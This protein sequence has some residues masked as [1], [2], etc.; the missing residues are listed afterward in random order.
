MKR[1]EFILYLV[2]S[3][4]FICLETWG[5]T[6][7]VRTGHLFDAPEVTMSDYTDFCRDKEGY[8]WIG[9]ERGLIRFDGAGYDIYRHE[10]QESGSLSDNRILDLLYDSKGRLWVGTANGLNLYDRASDSFQLIKIPGKAFNG[11]II[12]MDEQV[13][14][15]IT[16]VLSGVGLYVIDDK[17]GNEMNA[18]RYMPQLLMEKEF[19]SLKCARDGKMYVGDHLGSV[20]VIFPNGNEKV[21]PVGNSYINGIALEEDGNLIISLLNNLYRLDTKTLKIENLQNWGGNRLN[22]SKMSSDVI[23][24]D[25]YVGTYGEGVWRISPADPVVKPCKDFYSPFMDMGSAEVSA[26]YGGG[27]ENL[28]L[29][30]NYKGIMMIPSQRIPFVYRRMSKYLPGFV[31]GISAL[32][33]SGNNLLA[34]I[35]KDKICIISEN[36]ELIKSYNLPE[37]GTATDIEPLGAGKLL[38]GVGNQGVWQ[39]SLTDG[40]WSRVVDVAGDC[41]SISLN[42]CNK[43][44]LFI[45]AHGIGIMSYNMVSGEKKW[46][47]VDP[48]GDRLTNTY[49]N[50]MVKS[51][52]DKLW[53]GLYG[54]VACYDLKGD[55][56]LEINQDP[57]LSGSTYTFAPLGGGRMLAATSHGLI[58]VHPAKGVT[59]KYTTID[60]LTDNDVRSIT[61]DK[62]GGRWIGTMSGLSYQDPETK[63]IFAYHGNYGLVENSFR[64]S[65]ISES[66]GK[67]YFSN[68]QGITCF[69]PEDVSSPQFKSDVKISALYLKGIRVAPETK[70][71]RRMVIEGDPMKPTVVNLPYSDN[72]LS[73]RLSTMDF[74]DAANI[75]YR[76]RMAD[77]SEEWIETRPG[78]NVIYLPYLEPGSHVLQIQAKEN[79]ELSPVTEMK[80]RIS[81]P[82]YL[83]TWAK[84]FYLLVLAT[85]LLLGWL[86]MQKKK[87]EKINDA[88][89]KFFIDVSHDIRS[90]ITLILSP[91]ESLLKRPFDED[92]KRQLKTMQRNGQRIISLVNQLLDIRKLDKGKMRLS[93]RK[94]DVNS[95]VGELVDMFIPQAAECGLTLD[96]EPKSELN[97]IWIDRDN[98]DKVLV[99]LISNAIKYTPKGGGI[100]VETEKMT[101]EKLGECVRISVIDTGI[102]LDS[103]TEA[104]IFERFYR[105]RESHAPAT[106]GFGIGLDLCRRLA[107]LHHGS[108]S[109]KNRRDGVKGSVFSIRIP[110]DESFY[111]AEEFQISYHSEEV[112]E[113]EANK[114]L[115]MPE[116]GV[117]GDSERLSRKKSMISKTVLIVDDH[118]E[119]RNYLCYQLASSYKMIGAKDG[120]EAL[121][122][123]MDNTPDIIVSDVMM[124]GMDGLELLKRVKSNSTTHHVPVILLSSR[125]ELAD[126]MKGWDKGADGYLGKPFNIEE[127]EVVIDTLIE[128]RLRVK[129]K[130]TGVR[131][132]EEKI[133]VPKVKG[134]DEKLLEKIIKVIE[135]NIDDSEFNVEKLSIEVGM[136]RA[137]LHRKMKEKMGLNPSDFIRNI[138]LRRAC[139]LLRKPDIEVTQIAYLVGYTSQP[140]FSTAFK[141]FTGYT[142]SEYRNKCQ[143][144]S[145]PD[146]SDT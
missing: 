141:K 109:G 44:D 98:I 67:V 105:V 20:H 17:K 62:N 114:H 86:V 1:L 131:E 42:L 8:L 12:G 94:T 75:V 115:N 34:A 2:I 103:K 57:F 4:I 37:G 3:G 116:L 38:V 74:R 45:G 29:G 47:D 120:E 36:G 6:T 127:L 50:E 73:L 65:V 107:E 76:W 144:D 33:S 61:I 142:P 7:P 112:K 99:N 72:A 113:E 41:P 27:E 21:I 140:H 97:N 30:C 133:S 128:N 22:I 18:V 139:E 40:R 9:T 110:I 100:K 122:I 46:L 111:S 81:P 26:I 10:E 93:C 53:I 118:E 23:G 52:D 48:E 117:G 64:L 126:R 88:K 77:V 14:G 31:G 69:I 71:G 138:R 83:S 78:E 39:L 87:E 66:D 106:P 63:N 121:K 146:T 32:A 28:W 125:N 49:T 5:N 92:V 80:I 60:G 129:G 124:P 91:L 143:T 130:F 101:D 85:L 135:D 11:Y 51:D 136:S 16:F 13:D 43:E 79:K 90:P 95:F 132:V 19:N 123:I 137:H 24:G 89:I 104:K 102:G 96:F 15:T 59:A 108:I 70:A 25:I 145:M 119:L 134:N 84:L 56:L 68:D 35:G 54:G 58:E 82:W 55:S